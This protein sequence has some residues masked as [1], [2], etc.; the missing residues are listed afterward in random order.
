MFDQEFEKSI[1]GKVDSL[2]SQEIFNDF[3][4]DATQR[5]ALISLFRCSEFASQL[6]VK[7]PNAAKTLIEAHGCT[8]DVSREEY[9]L[10]LQDRVQA[11]ETFDELSRE[12]RQ[13][14]YEKTLRITWRDLVEKI[15]V[16]QTL[17]EIT[18]LADACVEVAM[19][20]LTAWLVEKH[21]QPVNAKENP[22]QLVVLAMGKMGA[23]ELNFSSDIDLIFCY[24]EEGSIDHNG[25]SLSH[26][27]FFTRLCQQLVRLLGEVTAYGF[28]YRVDTR[29][30]PFGNSGQ[31]ALSFDAME[32]YYE[33]HG[34]EWE[35][36][37]MVKARPI[38]VDPQ[39]AS[40][41][42]RILQPFVY[43]RYFDFSAFASLREMKQ[44]IDAEV[45]RKGAKRNVKLGP[46]GIR[47]IEFIG[48]AFQL[49]RGG[50]S[51]LLQK[52]SILFILT[53]LHEMSL[54]PEFVFSSLHD[55]YLFLRKTEN[56][57]QAFAEQQTHLLPENELQQLR[58]AYALGFDSWEG[59][60]EVLTFHME[61]VHENFEQ[62]FSAPQL[63]AMAGGKSGDNEYAN[64]WS[65]AIEE[66]A[67]ELILKKAGYSEP[68]E[69]LEKIRGLASSSKYRTMGPSG[70][71]R[72]DKLIPLLIPMVGKSE[73]P[74]ICFLRVIRLL[75]A[76]AKRTAYIALLVEHPLGLSQLVQLF[77]KSQWVSDLLISHPL[78]M[79]ELIDPRRLY[80]PVSK[81]DLEK[82]LSY[83]FDVNSEDV[84]RQVQRL[85]DFKQ[86]NFLR[87]AASELMGFMPVEKVSDHLTYIA[88]TSVNAVSDLAKN[89]LA[90]RF[91]APHYVENGSKREAGFCVIAYG[92]L[93]GIE[94]G[95]GSDLDLVFLH[96][97][98][99][100]QQMTDGEK[101]VDNSVFY[102]KLG[103]RIILFLNT[104]TQSGKLYEVDMRL[105][106]SGGSGILV[107]STKSFLDYQKN[108]AW[109][110]EHQAL[111]RARFI[112]GGE[113]LR[114]QFA[115]IRN[116]ILCQQ[117]DES[118]L[119]KDVCDMRERMRGE[120]LKA[121]ENK[122][123]LKQSP[124]GITDIEFIIQF[125]VLR[126][127]HE[128]P[129]II[130]YTDNLRLLEALVINTLIVEDDAKMLRSAYLTYRH[131]VH[132][133]ALQ[134]K[135]TSSASELDFDEC[136]KN[137]IKI[138]HKI[139]HVE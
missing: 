97:S 25:K 66:S 78:L 33:R 71:S 110:W 2:L 60:H 120:L 26:R 41:L 52:R 132:Q 22:M 50:R 38:S 16:E 123:D 88:E 28:V 121:K 131:V 136:R 75:E 111:V 115:D 94:L 47:E 129:Q 68:A 83:V 135:S 54:I 92:K 112:C 32:T 29:L 98:H 133:Y 58:L 11:I 53:T 10:L 73:N 96:D 6:C 30:R 138:W 65:G 1:Q 108:K 36:Y 109:T 104:P 119:R 35:R 107:S 128:Y 18:W 63:D 100:E 76:I 4:A 81:A 40:E 24:Q 139:M 114:K 85:I 74:E 39:A 103:Q 70:K 37:A 12:L 137:V 51:P 117:R 95:F 19:A 87:V 89:E 80:E 130:E 34:R 67:A 46:G 27:E 3:V 62:I 14:R 44:M 118:V 59:F 105:R 45:G 126:W 20:K 134:D 86:S 49:I 69:A 127:A 17:R 57:I 79:D 43:R 23:D 15:S 106:P 99:A 56:A 102:A 61:A 116:H 64:I 5:D 101:T 93:G 91:G 113:A 84:E 42:S 72:F 7:F 55:A 8:E 125:L 13:Y 90:K 9:Q 122:F 31:L 48:Q 82:E 77:D 21:G 124:G